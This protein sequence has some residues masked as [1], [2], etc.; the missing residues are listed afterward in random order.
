VR[1]YIAWLKGDIEPN[2]AVSHYTT[3]SMLHRFRPLLSGGGLRV[4]PLRGKSARRTAKLPRAGTVS[5]PAVPPE[6]WFPLIRA[7][8]TYVHDFAPDILRGLDRYAA[9]RENAADTS[10]G[11]DDRFDAWLADPA[12]RIP[13]HPTPQGDTGS[14]RV[15][16]SLFTLL[17]GIDP[18]HD[19]AVF[20]T[21]SQRAG[22][23]R[24]RERVDRAVASG[25]PTV[26]GI[27][28]DLVQVTRADGSTGPWHPG[29]DPHAV[30]RERSRLRDAC[31]TLVVGLSM[32][33]DSEIHEITKGSVVEHYG[34]PAVAS[35][36]QK[37]DPNL[38]I[39]HWWIIEPVAEAIA[40]AEHLSAHP[41]RVFAPLRRQEDSQTVV[42]EKMLRAFI[43]HVNASRDQTGLKAVPDGKASP[44]MFRKTMA[45]LTDQF[46]GSEIA[47]GIQLKHVA[48]RAL[49]N[50]S[51]GGYAAP[52]M[53]W[54][55]HLDTAIEA[56]RFRRLED[57]YATHKSGQPIGYGPAA[58]RIATVFDTIARNTQ[59]NGGDAAV[60]R[61][62]L[63]KS[64]I[65]LRFGV[66][67]HCAFDES[68]PAGAVCLEK[69]VIP[70]GHKGPLQDRCRPDRCANS[71]VGPE[72]VPIWATERHTLLTLITTPGL[73]PF[74]R[75]TLEREL[76]GVEAVLNKAGAATDTAPDF[77]T[78]KELS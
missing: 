74:R 21:G 25:Y 28:D 72:H 43:R 22:A 57:L 60:E 64:R 34:T 39:K 33:R 56:A 29:L 40:V 17:L 51:T 41:E 10:A 59:A 44:H 45:M 20:G 46:A 5:T 55:K 63:R 38:P 50:R 12:N 73:A 23:L 36:K 26:T 58:D 48:T 67:N 70:A 61:A 3:L 68:N 19:N 4:E 62:L 69:A 78:D 65:S 13:V 77:A 27:V 7:A 8:W 71:V 31:Y 35:T 18:R 75:Q 76:A 9:L 54:A 49:A 47:L 2:T 32:M 66:L 52:D 16:Y 30:Q 42:S 15:N 6:V 37:H 14:P 11:V 1:R 24:R 53:S